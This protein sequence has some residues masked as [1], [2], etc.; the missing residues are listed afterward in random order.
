MVRL[1]KFK[2]VLKAEEELYTGSTTFTTHHHI[3][4][5]KHAI[6]GACDHKYGTTASE[7]TALEGVQNLRA[8][9]IFYSP[10]NFYI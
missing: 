8:R 4:V 1:S 6:F 2:M 9:Y 5:Q 3:P 10:I 7:C